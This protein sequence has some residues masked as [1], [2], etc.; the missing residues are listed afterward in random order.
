MANEKQLALQSIVFSIDELRK[1]FDYSNKQETLRG[2][3]DCIR[4]LAESYYIIANT[5]GNEQD[6]K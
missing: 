6:G 2:Y 5:K 4:I 1:K 3:C